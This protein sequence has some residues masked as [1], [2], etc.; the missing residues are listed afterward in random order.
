MRRLKAASAHEPILVTDETILRLFPPLRQAWGIRGMQV[1]VPITGCNDRRVLFG[2][3]NVRTGHRITRIGRSMR[4]AEFHAFLQ[5]LRGRYRTGRRIWL[6]LD[7]HGTH[8]APSTHKLAES[9][10]IVLL[11]LPKQCPELNPMDH[12]WREAK[13]LVSANRQFPGI[14]EHAAAAEA[15]VLNLTPHEALRTS[16]CLSK[17]F[18]LPT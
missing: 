15:W 4:L 10:G 14:Q 8:D 5:A 18:W 7:R 13:R 16:G 11:F 6:V 12:L 3:V 17:N 2:A 1:C 9:L